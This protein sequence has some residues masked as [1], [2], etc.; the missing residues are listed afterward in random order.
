MLNNLDLDIEM[1]TDES[2]RRAGRGI[3]TI[4]CTH[5]TLQSRLTMAWRVLCNNSFT[6]LMQVQLYQRFI[7]IPDDR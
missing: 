3:M 6:L 5:R 7:Q 1:R 2:A 4:E